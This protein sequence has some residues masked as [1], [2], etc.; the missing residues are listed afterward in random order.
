MLCPKCR[1]RGGRSCERDAPHAPPDRERT[2]VAPVLRDQRVHRAPRDRRGCTASPLARSA[3]I[4]VRIQL[5]P[6]SRGDGQPERGP[7]THHPRPFGGRPSGETSRAAHRGRG[8]SIRRTS[9]PRCGARLAGAT[10]PTSASLDR[11][12]LARLMDAEMA[13]VEVATPLP[14]PAGS[15]PA[16]RSSGVPM[17]WMVEWAEGRSRCSSRRPRRAFPPT[18][19]A[20]ST[21]TSASATPARW[22]VTARTRPSPP[23]TPAPPAGSPTC[24]PRKTRS[25]GRRAPPPF[26]PSVLAVHADR[27]RRQSLRDRLAR[28][29]TGRPK[30]MVHDHNS[31][32]RST[33]RSPGCGADGRVRPSGQ[34]RAAGRPR[35]HDPVVPFNDVEAL[36][37]ELANGDVAVALF[38][39]A[40]TNVG[41]V[42]PEPG[43]HDAVRELTRRHGTLLI[44]DETHTICAGPG[45]YTA[46]RRSAAGHARPSARRSAVACPPGLRLQRRR[47]RAD[48]DAHDLGRRRCRRD[49][50]TLAGNALSM[51]AIAAT[52][53]HVLTDEAFAR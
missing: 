23:S 11:N 9:H 53:T 12:R 2:A 6:P 34:R 38:E 17:N 51:A 15:A 29:I 36:E 52:L 43:Y 24:C 28:E 27:D 4:P 50:R 39:P 5:T 33:R 20:T 8:A 19:T 49:R 25:G 7:E 44:I 14:C 22:R 1:E 45:G 3:G 13:P 42:L 16:A 40:L 41:I 10:M 48:P 47:R 31:T 37:R 26:R 18:S 35:D 32:A 30:V 46:A 21:S